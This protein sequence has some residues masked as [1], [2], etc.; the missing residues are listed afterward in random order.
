MIALVLFSLSSP[1]EASAF[2]DAVA[3]EI[4]VGPAGG[5][6]PPGAD[7]AT[8]RGLGPPCPVGPVARCFDPPPPRGGGGGGPG[9]LDGGGVGGPGGLRVG[10]SFG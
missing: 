2:I 9:P 4:E 6:A 7:F 10:A 5:W 1:A 8:T 3:E